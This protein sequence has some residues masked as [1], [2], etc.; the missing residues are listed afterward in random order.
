MPAAAR[1]GT[2]EVH[3][4]P[5]EIHQFAKPRYLVREGLIQGEQLERFVVYIGKDGRLECQEREKYR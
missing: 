5:K 1:E 2:V 4:C 3:A